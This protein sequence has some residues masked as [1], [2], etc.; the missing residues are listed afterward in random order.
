MVEGADTSG[1]T[2][3]RLGPREERPRCAATSLAY[4]NVHPVVDLSPQDASDGGTAPVVLLLHGQPGIA[5]EW[6]RVVELLAP[7]CRVV[8]PE[9]PG[10]DGRP[11]RATDWA[12]NA[13]AAV[14]L[15]DDLA[16]DS[17]VVA[18]FSWATGAALELGRRYPDRV[19]GLVL[20]G[21]LGAVGSVTLADRLATLPGVLQLGRALLG[22][23][24]PWL[25][26][27]IVSSA[28]SRLD[29]ETMRAL[30]AVVGLWRERRVWR[31]AAAEQRYLVRDAPA[32]ERWVAEVTVP[33]IVIAGRRDPY[34]PLASAAAL[35]RTLPRGRLVEVDAGHLMTV[36]A[37]DA[38]A[39]AVLE[40]VAQPP[41]GVAGPPD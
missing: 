11:E 25:A 19:R 40:L 20:V 29:A 23:T 38:I 2:G 22:R 26:A 17:V 36:E 34:I 28:R 5:A 13:D 33:A 6:F 39:A 3:G 27:V 4:P 15:L 35:A 32:L 37:P 10:Y 14:R 12:G 16:V 7:T 21:S 24:G 31:A 18:A 41:T 30:R 9:R 8:A 1:T